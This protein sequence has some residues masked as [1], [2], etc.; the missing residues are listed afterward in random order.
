MNDDKIFYS[1]KHGLAFNTDCFVR[2]EVREHVLHVAYKN[3]DMWGT[4]S[5]NIICKTKNEAEALLDLIMNK[6]RAKSK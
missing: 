1:K 4:E 5:S 6:V 2:A 3:G